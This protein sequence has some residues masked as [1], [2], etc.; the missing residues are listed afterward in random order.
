[1][2]IEVD[3]KG[4]LTCPVTGQ[5]IHHLNCCRQK[6]SLEKIKGVI[7]VQCL[8]PDAEDYQIVPNDESLIED[9]TPFIEDAE[10]APDPYEPAPE[11]QVVAKPKAK[12]SLKHLI[13][14]A[15][16][17]QIRRLKEELREDAKGGSH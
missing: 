10:I 12:Y 8:N 2:F 17:E 3:K 5:E 6:A 4:C 1:M 11:D 16:T 7:F 15:N 9:E 13:K 14:F